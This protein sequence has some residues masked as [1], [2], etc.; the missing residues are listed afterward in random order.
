MLTPLRRNACKPLP[1]SDFLEQTASAPI[2]RPRPVSPE[3]GGAN[4]PAPL[5]DPV[6][7]SQLRQRLLALPYRPFLQAVA[8]LLSAQGYQAVAPAGRTRFKGQNAGGWDL[9]ARYAADEVGPRLC[10]ARVKQFDAQPVDLRYVDE[11]RGAALR[12]GAHEALLITLSTFS[13]PARLGALSRPLPVRL[14]DGEALLD[15]LL[16]QEVGVRPVA[17]NRKTEENRKTGESR[18]TGNWEV[19]DTYFRLLERRFA[20]QKAAERR[21]V[22]KTAGAAEGAMSARSAA[23]PAGPGRTATARCSGREQV[24]TFRVTI[25]LRRSML[26]GGQDGLVGGR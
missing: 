12:A 2:R 10:V 5:F 3:A 16:G 24:P 8:H 14:V 18:K 11:L 6:L 17:E 21:L 7:R 13:K 15:D 22:R 25:T 26:R 1:A 23:P 4:G 19:D 20:E 9:E